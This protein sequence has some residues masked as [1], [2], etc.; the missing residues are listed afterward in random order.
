MVMKLSFNPKLIKATMADYPVIQNMARF[1]AYDMSRYCG[2]ISNEWD[3]PK[4]GLYEAHDFKKYFEEPDRKAFLVKI[5]D[6]L[7][8]FVLLNKIGTLPDTEWDMGEFYVLAKFQGKGIAKQVAFQ[9]WQEF[10]GKWEVTVI[11][12]NLIGLTFWRKTVSNFTNGHYKEEIKKIDYDKHQPKRYILSF[13]TKEHNQ[14]TE[15]ISVRKAIEA[16]IS[17]MSALS[18]KKR[19][20]YEKAQPQFWRYAEGAE[21]KQNQWFKELLQNED[22]ILLVAELAK[23][24][25]G[26]IIARVMPAPS[27]YNPGGLTSMVDDFCVAD[28]ELWNTVGRELISNLKQLSKGKDA[29]QI[30][31]VC[32]SHDEAKR[33]FLQRK[34]LTV[35]SEWYVGE[36]V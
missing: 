28:T 11:P 29:T 13:N 34:G 18:R 23:K 14:P 26:F 6:E 2:F 30:V 5:E 4:D 16:D 20:E 3:F 22:Y 33:Q 15:T 9:I 1:Y 35:A 12:E 19:L 31:V 7:A 27:V 24:M 36:I 17:H 21:E 8:G 25:M 32:G 10:N